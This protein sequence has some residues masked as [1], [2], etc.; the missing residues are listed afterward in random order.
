MP[1]NMTLCRCEHPRWCHDTFLANPDTDWEAPPYV[2]G[3]PGECNHIGP[4][5]WDCG[6]KQFVAEQ[7]LWEAA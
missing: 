3:E 5:G 1:E 6:C 2:L 4:G 7:P